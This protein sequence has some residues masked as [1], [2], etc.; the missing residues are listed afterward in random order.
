[1]RL[2]EIIQGIESTWKLKGQFEKT[3][4]KYNEYSQN[5]MKELQKLN[6]EQ[7]NIVK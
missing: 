6:D 7:K 3:P 1:M 5:I 2:N 4:Q